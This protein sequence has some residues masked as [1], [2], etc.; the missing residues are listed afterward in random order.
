MIVLI[1]SKPGAASSAHT[2]PGGEA[3]EVEQGKFEIATG[4]DTLF[5]LG[6]GPCIGVCLAFGGRGFL[7]HSEDVQHSAALLN[8]FFKVLRTRI[9]RPARAQIRPL[10]AGGSLDPYF[11]P[12]TDADLHADINN[13]WAYFERRLGKLGFGPPVVR[14]GTPESAK[15]IFLS[16]RTKE[17]V[18]QTTG[19]LRGKSI[20]LSSETFAL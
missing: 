1:Q 16:L 19:I 7:F 15:N 14:R 17:I 13:S 10:L 11:D 12:A 20:E 6:L 5:T 2:W 9:P 18:L 3:M 4:T 8:L